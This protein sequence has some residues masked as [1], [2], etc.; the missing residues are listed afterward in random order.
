MD[1][2]TVRNPLTRWLTF[3]VVGVAVE[4]VVPVIVMG[5][6]D[7]GP[8]SFLLCL[9]F[10][11]PFVLAGLWSA[12]AKVEV[13]S[14]GLHHNGL[15]EKRHFGWG[16][17]AAVGSVVTRHSVNFVPTG[18]SY[19]VVLYCTNGKER[20]LPAPHASRLVGRPAFL[21]SAAALEHAVDSGKARVAREA[22]MGSAA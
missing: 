5:T 9:L 8:D 10:S 15:L 20:E 19:K 7:N 4:F 11:V 6:S 16:E 2:L 12:R 1:H 18:T 13:R 21:V 3:I 14:D 17:I 22:R